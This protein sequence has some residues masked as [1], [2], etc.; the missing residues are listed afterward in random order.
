MP[1]LADAGTWSVTA[2]HIADGTY[3]VNASVSA[4]GNP[5]SANQSLT[6]DTAAPAGRPARWRIGGHHRPDPCNHGKWRDAGRDRD[7][8]G[9]RSDDDH[10]SRSGW[11][12][13]GDPDRSRCPPAP[14]QSS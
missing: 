13:V 3:T 2:T 5:G 6:I 7:R 14:T 12:V 9:R 1:V 11:H 10:N 4:G 8:D